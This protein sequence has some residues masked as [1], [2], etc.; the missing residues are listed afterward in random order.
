MGVGM[1]SSDLID[2][3]RHR[4]PPKGLR[5]RFRTEARSRGVEGK[6][7]TEVAKRQ[8]ILC[9]CRT[10]ATSASILSVFPDGFEGWA[11]QVRTYD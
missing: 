1:Q 4:K 7:G 5:L 11:I 6:F 8:N 9:T 2:E 3:R 10:E